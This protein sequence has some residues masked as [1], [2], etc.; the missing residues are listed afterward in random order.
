VCVCV[1]VYH[2][3]FRYAAQAR[4]IVNIVVVNENPY[5]KMIRQVCEISTCVCMYM[6]VISTCIYVVV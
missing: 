5:M 3:Y 4:R 1:C 6:C 2:I